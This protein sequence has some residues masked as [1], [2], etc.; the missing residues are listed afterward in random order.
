M[1]KK[2]AKYFVYFMLFMLVCG[3]FSRGIYA[4][5]ISQV[6]LEA[7]KAQSISHTIKAEGSISGG[8]EHAVW[9]EA[10]IHVTTVF[11]KP[12]Q[13]VAEQD[14]LF[15]LDQEE[16]AHLLQEA[17]DTLK[18]EQAKLSDLRVNQSN[19]EKVEALEKSR[20]EA[21]LQ[22]TETENAQSLAQAQQE[23]DASVTK[24]AEYPSWSVYYEKGKQKMDKKSCKEA[25]KAGKTALE[26]VVHEKKE[27]WQGLL[28]ESDEKQKEAGRA[29]EDAEL[30]NKDSSSLLSQEQIVKQQ[31]EVVEKYQ[32]LFDAQGIITSPIQGSVQE[33]LVQTGDETGSGAAVLLVDGSAGWNFQAEV[34]KEEQ[35]YLKT[36]ETVSVAFSSTGQQVDA[37]EI[38]AVEKQI[39]SDRFLVTVNL[40]ETDLSYGMAGVMEVVKQSELYSCC[41]PLSAL[42]ADGNQ[43]YILLADTQSSILGEELVSRKVI[44]EVVEKNEEYAALSGTPATEEDRIVVFSDR[45]IEPGEKVRLVE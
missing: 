11:V 22:E 15:Q 16:I 43:N 27:A 38:T 17:K 36:G 24:L 26:A 32:A 8:A 19:A 31:Q 23:Y 35:N 39:D 30:V 34:D 2:I 1:K 4:T 44:V 25:W 37:A 33:V 13:N 42:Y 9:T 7:P 5:Q 29:L 41:V 40:S 45:Q 14:P 21:D 18:V 12:Q 20:A 6:T 10:G 28:E 3:I